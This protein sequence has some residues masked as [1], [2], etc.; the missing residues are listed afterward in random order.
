MATKGK[1]Y[2]RIKSVQLTMDV[3]KFIA[4]QEKPVTG[5][6][7]AKGLGASVETVMCHLTT[8]EEGG[9]VQ[10]DSGQY[11]LG[12]YMA[13]IRQSVKRRLESTIEQA[14]KDLDLI[15]KA[16]QEGYV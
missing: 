15:K 4:R 9:F 10:E 3:I 1:S 5:N 8:L 6:V 14:Q 12:V 2:R 13:V 16:E 11:S 7:I